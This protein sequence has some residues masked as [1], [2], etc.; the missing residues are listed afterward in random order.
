MELEMLVG[1]Q[2]T[3]DGD[4]R[5]IRGGNQAE[6]VTG[7]MSG[8]HYEQMMRGNMFVYTINSQTLLLAATGGGHPTIVNPPGSGRLFVPVSLRIGFISSAGTTIGSVVIAETT[9]VGAI[10]SV[11]SGTGS[12]ILTGTRV[13]P[14]NALRGSGRASD[15]WWLPTTNTFSAAPTVIY[16]TGINLGTAAPSVPGPYECKFDGTLG[17]LPGTAMSVCYSV[18]SATSLF[19][20]TILGLELPLPL[21]A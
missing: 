13:E 4:K 10:A 15:M 19:H 2:R 11:L 5:P 18:A 7:E 14:F 21:A 6:I 12:P 17:F 8:K 9:K 3:G 20:I 16:A 1:A